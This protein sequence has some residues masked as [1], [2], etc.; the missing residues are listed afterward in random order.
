VWLSTGRALVKGAEVYLIPR[1]DGQVV[2]GATVEEQGFDRSVSVRGVHDLLR[3]ACELVPL[4]TELTFV[5]AMAGLR[6]GTPDNGPIVGPADHC[7]LAGL[8]VATGHYRNGILLSALTGDVVAAMVAGDEVA[9][10]WKPFAA[11]RF[12]HPGGQ[13]HPSHPSTGVA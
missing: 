3:D 12:S 9:L 1:T 8:V 11:D 2:V 6:P 10:E 4:L 5:E 13:T 7:G